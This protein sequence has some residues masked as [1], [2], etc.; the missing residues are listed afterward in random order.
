MTISTG[1]LAGDCLKFWK[2]TL[3]LQDKLFI[4]QFNRGR[5]EALRHIYEKYKDD[6]V[7]LAAVLLSDASAAEDVVHDVFVSFLKSFEK[8][9]NE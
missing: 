2:V 6:L 1:S 3:M 4:W 5:K 8:E 7:T 9:K